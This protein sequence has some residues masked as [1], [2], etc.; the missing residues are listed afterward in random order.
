[1]ED[2]LLEKL[3]GEIRR[4]Q[5]KD[6]LK[7]TMAVSAL[8]A[9]ADD[10][11]DPAEIAA[12]WNAVADE[13]AL[14]FFDVEKAQEILDSYLKSIREE[15]DVA[16]LVLYG[17]VKRMRGDAKRSRTLL[18]VAYLIIASDRLLLRRERREFRKLCV[19]LD[20]EP[21]RIW[22]ELAEDGVAGA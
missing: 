9:A 21:S 18:R 14:Q 17:K 15:G 19:A 10:E 5:N 8:A 22:A 20:M 16:R 3:G 2:S 11:V 13:P 12:L 1:M 6:F 7:A 4:Y